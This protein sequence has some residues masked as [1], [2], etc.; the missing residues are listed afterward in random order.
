M[1]VDLCTELVFHPGTGNRSHAREI[2]PLHGFRKWH[3]LGVAESPELCAWPSKATTPTGADGV[4]AATGGHAEP[5]L[6]WSDDAIRRHAAELYRS[7][8]GM[9]RNPADAEDLVQETFARAFAASA[10]FQ[11][12]TN[13]GAWLYRIMFNA[14]V[15][16]YRRRQCDPLRAVD[17]PGGQA[18]LPRSYCSTDSR[19]AEECALGSVG[20]A[21]IIAVIRTLPTS[22]RL[23][24]Y[25][26]AVKGLGYRDIGARIKRSRTGPRLAGVRARG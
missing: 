6:I 4:A 9:T 3:T 2:Q 22:C 10:Q 11:P 13:M 15:S 12:G 19:S 21:E 5:G 18:N 25:R 24:V 1:Q 26:A 14:F 20:H 7:A 23:T 8:F 17:R 16:D